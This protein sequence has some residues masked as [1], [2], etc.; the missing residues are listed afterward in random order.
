MSRTHL[1]ARVKS[2]KQATDGHL[3][4]LAEANSAVLATLGAGIP[5]AYL[6]PVQKLK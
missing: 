6:I 2:A 1:P 3:A 5:G 4:Q